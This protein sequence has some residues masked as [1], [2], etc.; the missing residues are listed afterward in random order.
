[1]KEKLLLIDA[2][3]LIHRAYHALPPLTGPGNKPTGALYGL[4]SILIKLFKGGYPTY[5]A[6]AFDRPEPT[7]R[8]EMYKE[9]KATRPPTPSPL[10]EQLK[11]ARILLGHFGV[12]VVESPGYEADDLIATLA[13]KFANTNLQ[14]E[15]MSGDLDI[16]QVVSKDQIIAQI[17]KKGISETIIYNEDKVK[18]RFGVPPKTMADYK[19]LVG[20][21][22]DNIPGV[23]GIGPKSAVDL[24]ERYKNIE[25]I[26][27]NLGEIKKDKPALGEKLELGRESALLSKKLATLI[28]DVALEESL[29]TLRMGNPLR[30]QG[31][32]KYLEDL[33]FKTLVN[34]VKDSQQEASRLF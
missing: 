26:Y 4:T 6:A 13:T 1:M 33:G 31:L 15:I 28:T 10:I 14:A 25:N 18:E 11:E 23:A 29:D 21:N 12:R 22:S 3:S 32:W 30:D 24:L 34:R 7:L 27:Q 2:N 20:D 8:D 16:L 19:G 5:V 9:Y 17:P